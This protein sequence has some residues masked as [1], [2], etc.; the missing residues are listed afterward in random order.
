[1]NKRRGPGKARLR[2]D[3]F[4]PDDRVK[5]NLMVKLDRPSRCT[6]TNRTQIFPPRRTNRTHIFPLRPGRLTRPCPRPQVEAIARALQTC[7]VLNRRWETEQ[8][9]RHLNPKPEILSSSFSLESPIK[10]PLPLSPPFPR[11]APKR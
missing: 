10:R 6:R 5:L 9:H 7:G 3:G 1:M 4:D 11:A 2:R 8:A